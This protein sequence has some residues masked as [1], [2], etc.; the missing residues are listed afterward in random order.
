MPTKMT[1]DLRSENGKT[2][3][4]GLGVGLGLCLPILIC[5]GICAWFGY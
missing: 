5:F 1:A 2:T 4:I 3:S